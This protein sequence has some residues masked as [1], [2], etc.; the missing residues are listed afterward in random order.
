ML[1]QWVICHFRQHQIDRHKQSSFF[2]AN[3]LRSALPRGGGMLVQWVICHFKRHQIDRHKQSSFFAANPLRLALPRGGGCSCNG[4][5]ATSS[6]IRSTGTSNPPSSL[7]TRFAR[8]CHEGGMLVQ[9][10]IC[11]FKRHQIDRHKQSSFFA[12]NPLR[13]ALPRGGGDANVLRQRA[14]SHP[15]ALDALLLLCPIILNFVPFCVPIIHPYPS[16]CKSKKADRK[17][18]RSA[19]RVCVIPSFFS[20]SFPEAHRPLTGAAPSASPPRG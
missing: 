11:H 16:E 13:S 5:S 10:V 4:S 19:R 3:P 20:A 6:G 17:K 7:Q 18:L 2:A 1:V 8:L 9:W 14:T 12:A 15:A